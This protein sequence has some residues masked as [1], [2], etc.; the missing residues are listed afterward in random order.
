MKSG[1]RA[2]EMGTSSTHS[3]SAAR[4]PPLYKKAEKAQRA[5]RGARERDGGLPALDEGK[6]NPYV[7][8][9]LPFLSPKSAQELRHGEVEVLEAREL[10]HEGRRDAHSDGESH[11]RIHD[12]REDSEDSRASS[13]DF[14][15]TL[16]PEVTLQPQTKAQPVHEAKKDEALPL[17]I[18]RR[19]DTAFT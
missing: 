16:L 7:A 5:D 6:S 8:K 18:S 15:V 1:G 10:R 9:Q 3:T 2:T 19:E 13:V 11:E 14:D 12:R 4:K 17:L